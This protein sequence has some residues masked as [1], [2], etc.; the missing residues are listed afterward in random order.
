M[1][2]GKIKTSGIP[3]EQNELTE[4]DMEGVSGGWWDI[5]LIDFCPGYF[6]KDSCVNSL[7]GQCPRLIVENES[8]ISNKGTHFYELIT[9]YSCSKGCFN[10]IR[11]TTRIDQG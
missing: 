6:A 4:K 8:G 3:A 1:P 7:F 5:T 11:Y 10:K 9:I 2:E